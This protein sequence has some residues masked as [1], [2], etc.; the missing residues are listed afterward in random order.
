[1]EESKKSKL[2]K[3]GI[4]GGFVLL[5]LFVIITSIILHAKQVELDKLKKENERITEEV[6]FII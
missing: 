1:M 5:V 2:K 4:I 6:Q 3:W